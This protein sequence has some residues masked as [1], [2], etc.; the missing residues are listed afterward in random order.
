LSFALHAPTH[1]T[2]GLSIAAG[3]AALLLGW[4]CVGLNLSR[5][6]A[7]DDT[8]YLDLCPSAPT[9]ASLRERIARNPGDSAAYVQ[10]ALLD[11]STARPRYVAAAAQL[12]PNDAN[13]L[14]LQARAALDAQD[15]AHAVEPLVRLTDYRENMNASQVLA[16]LV[17]AGQGQLLLPYVTPGS[18]WLPRALGELSPLNAPFSAVLPLVSKALKAGVLSADDARVY[19]RQLKR[20]GAWLDAYSLWVSLHDAPL[21]ALYNGS[22]EDPFDPDGFDWEPTITTPAG[23]AGAVV[24]RRGSDRHGAVLDIH[25]TG[26]ALPV[27]LVRQYVFI[28]SGRYR[29]RG[30]YQAQQFR[31]EQGLAWSVH[32]T[33]GDTTAGR[34]PAL[35][36]T[37]GI[38]RSFEFDFAVPPGCGAVVSLQL[39]TFAPFEAALGARGRIAFDAL[40]LEK[41]KP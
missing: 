27:P 15:W 17:A 6:C 36:D 26:R 2:I 32:C 21:P 12:A 19:L 22:F 31:M 18:R 29:V 33:A 37:G 5:G 3:C 35:A 30:E 28:G 14:L 1:A 38:W 23:R 40:T 4:A 24:E 10:L 34:S 13:V 16:R 9:P 7:V 25:F 20:A 11:R 41:L 8:P 39:E